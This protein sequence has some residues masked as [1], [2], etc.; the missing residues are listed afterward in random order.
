MSCGAVPC[1]VWPS[2]SGIHSTEAIWDANGATEVSA[3]RHSGQEGS[4]EADASVAGMES[5]L[6]VFVPLFFLLPLL[7]FASPRMTSSEVVKRDCNNKYWKTNRK[8]ES[9]R[10]NVIFQH[11][12]GWLSSLLVLLGLPGEYQPSID[13]QPE[14]VS[15]EPTCSTVHFYY[16]MNF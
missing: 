9:L 14:L 10:I 8:A 13:Q 2:S 12:E 5:W 16:Q 4:R 7:A 11:N 6:R 1:Q 15:L 3:H